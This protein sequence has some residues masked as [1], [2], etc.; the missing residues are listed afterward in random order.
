MATTLSLRSL[1]DNDKL[2]GPNFD[3]WYQK[4]KIILEHERILYVIMDPTPEEPA[5]NAKGMVRDTYQKWL[6]DRTTI[7]C[8]MLAAMNDEFSR[9]FKNTQPQEMLQMLN[10]SFGMPDDVER[11]K[12]VV[13]FSMLG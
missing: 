3:R 2:M 7:R 12:L 13:P 11:H 1:L 9:R 8:I 5:L 10:D 4:L 6:N